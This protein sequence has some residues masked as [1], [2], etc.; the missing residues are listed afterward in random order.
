MS[1]DTVTPEIACEVLAKVGLSFTPAEVQVEAREGRWLVRLPGQRLAW[2]AASDE[3]RRYLETERRVLRLLEERCTFGV[4]RVLLA[5]AARGFDV[6]AMVPGTSDPL[7]V[8][9]EVCDNVDLAVRFGN[10]VG[11]ILAQQHSRIVAADVVGWLPRHPTWPAPREWIRE[12]L[13]RVVGDRE[14]LAKADAV[15]S[16]YESVPISEGDRALVHTD[17]G[18]HNLGIDP[19]SYTVQ[20]IFDYGEAA[21]ADRHHDFRYLVLDLDHDELLDAALSVYEPI[22]GRAIQRG[23]VLLYHAA[24]AITFLAD[25]SGTRP[26]ERPCGRTLAEDLRWSKQAIARSMCS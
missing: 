14:L 9:A 26:E 8:F 24:C 18:F 16:S 25:R 1:F 7:R 3:G 20:G 4:P 10:A 22:V 19:T 13:S 21:W 5:D 12:R 6:R 15:M 11:T 23:R 2:F 17:V